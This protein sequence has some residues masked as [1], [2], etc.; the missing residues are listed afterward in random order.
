MF[1]KNDNYIYGP[2]IN[3]VCRTGVG[4]FQNTYFEL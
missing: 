3:P 2:V 4:S 1:L